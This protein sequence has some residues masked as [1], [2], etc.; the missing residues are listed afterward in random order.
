MVLTEVTY[1]SVS[2]QWGSVE[3]IHRN[4]LITGYS[5]NYRVQDSS[6]RTTVLVTV[7]SPSDGRMYTIINLEPSVTYT[8]EIA[9]VN[10]IG[11]ATNTTGVAV[12]THGM[13]TLGKRVLSVEKCAVLCRHVCFTLSFLAKSNQLL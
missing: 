5:I 6:E 12:L 13:H 7:D 1:S 2:F 11:T 3:C 9:A 4:G 10:T 8:V